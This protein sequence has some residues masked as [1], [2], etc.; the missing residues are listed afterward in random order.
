LDKQK[1]RVRVTGADKGREKEEIGN[2][3]EPSLFQKALKKAG[4]RRQK[5]VFYYGIGTPPSI[6]ATERSSLEA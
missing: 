6:R 4:G 5:A 1:F 3:Q 2:L